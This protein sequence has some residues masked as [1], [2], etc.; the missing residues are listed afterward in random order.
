MLLSI[1]CHRASSL[2]MRRECVVTGR[3]ALHC[4][5]GSVLRH[6]ASSTIF[7]LSF[8]ANAFPEMLLA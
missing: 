6:L 5:V 8:V 1:C 3:V 2:Q 4:P 7:G